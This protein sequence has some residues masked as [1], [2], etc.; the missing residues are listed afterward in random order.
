[1]GNSGCLPFPRGQTASCGGVIT[2]TSTMF[3]ELEGRLY[4]VDDTE[5][6]TGRV[7]TLRVVR[8]ASGGAITI[9]Q[10]PV[11]FNVGASKYWGGRIDGEA[12]ATVGELCKPI[13]DYY[14]TRLTTIPNHDLFYVVDDGP[15]DV[16]PQATSEIAAGKGVMVT[17]DGMSRLA[18][19]AMVHYGTACEAAVSTR[20]TTAQLIEVHGGLDSSTAG[21]VPLL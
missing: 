2:M 15:C 7:V 1:M 4:D 20:T 3:T 12:G 8:N 6:D 13:D 14:N 18:R 21:G 11:S 17:A 5:H 16:L 19:D 9:K 10:K